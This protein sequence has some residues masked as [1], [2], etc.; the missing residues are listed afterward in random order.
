[1]KN[2]FCVLLWL[3]TSFAWGDQ[4]DNFIGKVIPSDA[5]SQDHFGTAVAV[6]EDLSVVGA[7][8]ADAVYVYR[9]EHNGS[10]TKIAKLTP[11][12]GGS[13]TQFGGSVSLSDGI[14]AVGAK[15][16]DQ[17]GHSNSGAAYLYQ[18]LPDGTVHFLHK[19][20][21]HDANATDY[22]GSSVSFSH[23]ILAVGAPSDDHSGGNDAGS[24]YVYRLEH[25][26]SLS[27]LEKL[28]ASDANASDN[29]G[30]SVS[31]SY[32]LVA[33]GAP[34][35][36]QDGATY[37]YWQEENGSFLQIAKLLD[38][39]ANY[40]PGGDDGFGHAVSLAGDRLAVSTK[41]DDSASG[42]DSGAV[43]LF[44]IV[45]GTP[46]L[47]QEV[48]APDGHA[49][50]YFGYSLSLSYELLAVGAYKH[51]HGGHNQAGAAYLY[52]IE[53]NGTAGLI[54]KF[55]ADDANASDYFGSSVALSQDTLA[56]GVPQTDY[57]G[58]TDAGTVFFYDSW[59]AANR[60]PVD[61]LPDPFLGFS[62]EKEHLIHDL[63][64]GWL[65]S[66]E[67]LVQQAYGLTV[68]ATDDWN[69][70][71]YEHGDEPSP[72][73][74]AYDVDQNGQIVVNSL[75]FHLPALHLYLE[76]GMGKF[77]LAREMARMLMTKNFYYADIT[78]D[79]ASTGDWFKSGLMDFLVGADDRVLDI[80]GAEPTDSE[81]DALLAEVGDGETIVTEAQ[82]ISAYL[83]ARYLDF[84]LKGAG[85]TGG[86]KHMTQWMKGQFDNGAGAAN[87]GINHYVF[88]QSG[89]FS[90]TEF[91]G[92]M[93]RD[94]VKNHVLPKLDNNDTGSVL[95]GDVTGG[96]NL[97]W[98]SVVPDLHG[99]PQ[100]NVQYE[101]DEW[102]NVLEFE[103]ESPIGTVVGHFEAVD[104]DHH[105]TGW[106]GYELIEHGA[107]ISWPDAKAAADA[108]DEA[109]PFHWVYLAT[110][111]SE[112]EHNLTA[113]LAAQ[114]SGAWVG[115]SDAAVEGEWRWTEG[116]EGEEGEEYSGQG[117]LFWQGNASGNPVN[118]LFNN[119]ANGEPDG[120]SD[121]MEI[122]TQNFDGQNSSAYIL[123]FDQ[124]LTHVFSLVSGPGDD[125]NHLFV[126][127]DDGAL[128]TGAEFDYETDLS[129]Y[130]IR[131]RVTDEL[132]ASFEKIF[133]V[134]LLD[135]DE[136]PD[137]DGLHNNEDLDDDGDGYSDTEEIAANSDPRNAWSLPSVA[138]IIYVDADAEG[139]N[140]GTSWASAYDNLQAA[141]AEADGVNRTQIWVAE[142]VYRPDVGPG[143]TEGDRNS[144]FQLKNR[145]EIIGGFYG[146]EQT[147]EER[148][149]NGFITYLSGDIGAHHWPDDN[150]Y[151]VVN[152]A[153]VD[154]TAKLIDL[155]IGRGRADGPTDWD[156]RG[157]G[158]LAVNGSPSLQNL[159]IFHNHAV[160]VNSGGGG[161]SVYNGGS[162]AV[163][164]CI[165]Q[166]NSAE[167]GGA[168]KL[169]MGS[170]AVFYNALV[171][172]NQA[173]KGGAMVVWESNA[174]ITHST[175]IDNNAS[176]GG[177]IYA[178]SDA[179]VS[180]YNSI[181]WDN[182]ATQNPTGSI[183]QSSFASDHS[184]VQGGHGD[185]PD[186]DP[187][188]V[189]P[190]MGDFRLRLGS[191]AVDAGNFDWVGALPLDYGGVNRAHDAGPD[192]GVYE[193]AVDAVN[194]G[195][196]I[197][198]SGEVDTGP[199]RVWLMDQSGIKV[200][201]LELGAAG[202]Y[203]FVVQ[204]GLSYK[205]KAFRDANNDWWP[206]V[207]DPWD[208][209][210][211]YPI[212][213]NESRSDFHVHLQ[214]ALPEQ[215][216]TVS[217][218]V[219]YEGPVPGPVVVWVLDGHSIVR[220]QIL[221]EGEGDYSF[222][223]PKGEAY[224]ILA[225]KDGNENGELD[226]EWQVGE[227]SAMYGVLNESSQT[228]ESEVFVGGDLTDLDIEISYHGDHDED[229]ITDWEE[230]V[231]GLNGGNADPE[232]VE[233]DLVAEYLLDGNATDSSPN[234]NHGVVFGA[235]PGTNRFG[236]EGM[237]LFFDGEDDHVQL[238][239]ME[240][241]REYTMAVW[242]L[243]MESKGGGYFN[244]LSNNGDPVWGVREGNLNPYLFGRIEGSPVGRHE[245]THLM[246]VR[247]GE[248]HRLYL[249]GELDETANAS[250]GDD[251]FSVIGAYKPGASELDDREPFHGMIDDLL[252]WNS[253]LSPEDVEDFYY[254]ESLSLRMGLY[255]FYSLDGVAEEDFDDENDGVIHGAQ[256]GENRFGEEEMAL[257]FDGEDDYVQLP[258]L[259]LGSE[260]SL[261]VWIQPEEEKGGGYFNV[262]SNNGDP[263]WGVREGNLKQYLF[264]RVEGSPVARHEW[265]H[266]VL[267]RD[268]ATHKLY[269]NGELD[270]TA[271]FQ[272]GN[273]IF[274]VIGAYQPGAE[275]LDDRE[276][277]HGTIDDL[278][279]WDRALTHDEAIELHDLETDDH[280]EG[281]EHEEVFVP[282]VRT[283]FHEEDGGDGYVFS[284]Q[285]LTDGGSP[286]L[287]VGIFLSESIFGDELIWVPAELDPETQEFSVFFDELKPGVRYYYRAFARNAAGENVGSLRKLVTRDHAHPGA[288]WHDMPAIGEG[289]RAS[290]WFGAFRKF[291]QTNWIYHAKL[292]W[293]FAVPD[294][295]RGLWLWHRELGWLW[296]QEGAWPYLWRNQVSD[297]IYFHK[298]QD[299]RSVIY[300][301]GTSEYQ[302]LP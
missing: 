114:A 291:E 218:E 158:I 22:F 86:V 85:I 93:G 234:E 198:Y 173:D 104:L 179:N 178:G 127:G 141:L 110:V 296:T 156:R 164:S 259:E 66:A 33:V 75:E 302:I 161:L 283:G 269:K 288:W 298:I 254:W 152:A 101:I 236:R 200:K 102:A 77:L 241:G 30:H 32:G 132:N 227:P 123:E 162:P 214:D 143:Q 65:K 174:T 181:A 294:E 219:F 160:G 208:Y 115:A 5:D 145:L 138:K 285:I 19:V 18:V 41:G 70:T 204:R 233:S 154:R 117:L 203:S 130:S 193:G 11:S 177:A 247:D 159:A 195:G 96:P 24:A 297:W 73:H 290:E 287:E 103:E 84:R 189:D 1:M 83:A 72:V 284:G 64:T 106:K 201:Q 226:D 21:A 4:S 82:S 250:A 78:G 270:A 153:G 155:G 272:A 216:A 68:D 134:D 292:G 50:A 261:S 151:H 295:E 166:S 6:W 51:N 46:H 27:P 230:Y 62:D 260:Y 67:D 182:N 266:L 171:F 267:I 168:V 40:A 188:F 125:H 126:L 54:E 98:H 210:A 231:A 212:E 48:L 279:I 264:G 42:S 289:W 90:L 146:D 80:L 277:F 58:N 229:G 163:F 10:M 119:W 237:A 276:P 55:V 186:A 112:A 128:H 245:W 142:G 206:S 205:V 209:H 176:N 190:E 223:L 271:N 169:S 60:A 257:F 92:Q 108:A 213:I 95:G 300:D 100:S 252:V 3:A 47:L 36:N 63:Q 238:P 262:L 118:G 23:G 38:P 39:D 113:H 197:T 157:A 88:T 301:Y 133:F 248:T 99:P 224:E 196:N 170:S 61:I 109:D 59:A 37:L 87:S 235:V 131:V 258:L 286:V 94:F 2:Y 79:G 44:S 278:I 147:F 20:T 274:S 251:V 14:V 194:L 215:N 275:G 111:T 249:N 29:F 107:N 246:L 13:N 74:F 120:D 228:F 136:D 280:G 7:P 265:T 53:D 243:P 135:V 253:A 148:G 207:G 26:G 97:D 244:V 122:F 172:G 16:S 9:E 220:E 273:D 187:L 137:R 49:I 150:A 183:N 256:P 185:L 149:L 124:V 144:T 239:P 56:V 12:D 184:I 281:E 282:I 263:V 15:W 192:L 211:H 43:Y 57:W 34:S 91:K 76:A 293:V 116:P 232:P 31:T 165:F 242:V 35:H 299:G 71:V 28:T 175:L 69:V 191:P 202:P 268:G 105:G 167:W 17:G 8:N 199:F 52:R 255:A 121:Y 45:E 140:N 180:F 222:T 225:F 81:I 25:N 89:G 217:G 129:S 240:L 221:P 139:E